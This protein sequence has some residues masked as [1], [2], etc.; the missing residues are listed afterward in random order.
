MN[1]DSQLKAA[2]F[3]YPTL[4]KWNVLEP[5]MPSE[6]LISVSDLAEKLNIKEDTL[7]KSL[8]EYHIQVLSCCVKI[9]DIHDDEILAAIDPKKVRFEC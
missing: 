6:G 8:E 2:E 5:N 4:K 9:L 7:L 1:P 3:R